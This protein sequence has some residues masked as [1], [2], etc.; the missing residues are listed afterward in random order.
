LCR[1]NGQP[2]IEPDPP[3]RA[4]YLA[5]VGGG[6]PVNLVL[7]GSATVL[8]QASPTVR[9][10]ASYEWRTYRELRLRALLDSPDAFGST[11][12]AE[13]ASS[14]EQWSARLARGVA[15]NTDIALAAELND[16]LVGLAWV[17]I[18][19]LDQGVAHLYQ[20]WVAPNFRRRGAGRALLGAAID[21]A[22]AS[23]A[24]ALVLAVTCGDTPASRLY[25]GAGFRC[26][27][28]P[29]PLRPGSSVLAQTMRLEL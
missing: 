5:T 1:E 18:E 26:I 8:M 27:G 25:A 10:F 15:C 14:D 20:M 16:R 28:A 22:K 9:T 7:L 21:W 12:A 11:L 17:K 2:L 4:F 23:S 29:E 6:G 13:Q 19:A 3:I 24:Q